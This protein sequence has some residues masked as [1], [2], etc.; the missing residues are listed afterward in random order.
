VDPELPPEIEEPE[1]EHITKPKQ[2]SVKEST[3]RAS[4]QGSSTQKESDTSSSGDCSCECDM[5]AAA[6]ELCE[7]FC[8]DEFAACENP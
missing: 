6:D 7:F 5:R 2:N 3:A 1:P 4:S 8:E